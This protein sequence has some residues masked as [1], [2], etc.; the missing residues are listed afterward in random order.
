V[1]WRWPGL[2]LRHQLLVLRGEGAPAG[3]S[4]T[5][6]TCF[7]FSF[8][9]GFRLSCGPCNPSDRDG[10]SSVSSGLLAGTGAGN[11]VVERRPQI[12]CDLRASIWLMSVDNPL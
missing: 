6:I 2:A 1:I 10:L 4:Q 11:C 12:G 8:T 9:S 5:S 7:W 3:C